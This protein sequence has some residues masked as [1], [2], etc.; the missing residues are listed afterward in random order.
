MDMTFDVK[1]GFTWQTP[2][3][4]AHVFVE[5]SYLHVLA[6]HLFYLLEVASCSSCSGAIGSV[7]LHS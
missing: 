7:L 4:G 5:L 3:N 2:N 6:S 1:K